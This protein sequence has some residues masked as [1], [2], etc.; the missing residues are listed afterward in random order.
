ME[1]N[2]EIL[3]KAISGIEILEPGYKK[4]KLNPKL[5]H[6]DYAKFNIS[7][8]YGNI[9]FDMKKGKE[10]KVKAPK[11]IEIIKE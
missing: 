9:F 1:Q 3:K 7:T 11:N 6:L 8:P 2:A 4:I 5:Y 10:P